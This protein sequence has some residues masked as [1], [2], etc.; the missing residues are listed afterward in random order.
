MSSSFETPSSC[1]ELRWG[2]GRAAASTAAMSLCE[3]H[4]ATVA[5]SAGLVETRKVVGSARCSVPGE[6]WD[7]GWGGGWGEGRG[8]G[9]GEGWD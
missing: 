9:W 5:A 4:S 1:H 3:R 7:E 6:G 8:E 2:S